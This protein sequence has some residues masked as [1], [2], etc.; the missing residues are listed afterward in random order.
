MIRCRKP[1]AVDAVARHR[2]QDSRGAA[3]ERRERC[4]RSIAAQEALHRRWFTRPR[5]TIP[6][7]SPAGYPVPWRVRAAHL[8]GLHCSQRA[9]RGPSGRR[10]ARRRH[11]LTRAR[12]RIHENTRGGPARETRCA[13]KPRFTR[14]PGKDAR[15][16]ASNVV[17]VDAPRAAPSSWPSGRFTTARPGRTRRARGAFLSVKSDSPSNAKRARWTASRMRTALAHPHGKDPPG[18]FTGKAGAGSPSHA[19]EGRQQDRQ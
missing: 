12:T 9:R 15:R 4:T 8:C 7:G 18:Q 10:R 5:M 14:T 19:R 1:H 2:E 6:S 11:R 17:R 13:A 16:A 3:L